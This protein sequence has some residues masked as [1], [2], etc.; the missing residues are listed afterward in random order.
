MA[1]VMPYDSAEGDS[2][3]APSNLDERTADGGGQQH[4]AWLLA[5][6]RG[7]GTD[8]RRYL[9]LFRFCLVNLLAFGLLGAAYL[10]GYVDYVLAADPTNFCIVIFM[11]FLT[12]LGISAW[13]VTNTSWELNQT[14]EFDP[15]TKSRASHY[16][17]EIRG[18]TDQSRALS[19]AALKLKLGSRISVVRQVGHSLVMLGLVGTVIGFI[20]AL[21]GVDPSRAGDIDA[22]GP[23]VSNL[24]SGMSIA[25]YT[26]LVGSL[27]SLWM[28]V[29]FQILTS[30][31][32][33]LITAIVE[34]GE[35]RARA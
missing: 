35:S 25:L 31:T 3:S 19:A 26:T 17:A 27:L 2:G 6:A 20:I 28:M 7:T 8:R 21:S 14:H 11:V 12:G 13:K 1:H 16:L 5:R 29:N 22:V 24:I 15:M 34:L 32:V 4:L 9:L 18:R 33:N 23:M 30:G 10:Q